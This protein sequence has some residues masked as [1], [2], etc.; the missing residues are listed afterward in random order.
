MLV[1]FPGVLES[2]SRLVVEAKMMNCKIVTTP[3][4]LGAYYEDWFGMSGES[5]IKKIEEKIDSA[6]LLFEEVI[7]R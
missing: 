3:K 2:L 6:F 1:F 4:L 5:L 7:S